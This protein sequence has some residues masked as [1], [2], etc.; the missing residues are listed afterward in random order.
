MILGSRFDADAYAHG[1]WIFALRPRILVDG[2]WAWLQRV[3]R[4]PKT[5]WPPIGI[6]GGLYDYFEAEPE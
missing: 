1:E 4:R 6:I 5:Q 2:R 3:W